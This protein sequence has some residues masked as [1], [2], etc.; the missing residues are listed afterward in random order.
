MPAVNR[1]ERLAQ[2][3]DEKIA[4]PACLAILDRNGFKPTDKLELSEDPDAPLS[5]HASL[6]LAEL[7]AVARAPFE[8]EKLPPDTSGK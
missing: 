5:P 2:S 8:R 4:L 3:D 1:L 7:K 6:T